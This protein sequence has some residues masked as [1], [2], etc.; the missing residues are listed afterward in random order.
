[1]EILIA[2]IA[3]FFLGLYAGNRT[4]RTWLNAIIVGIYRIITALGT[5]FM[6]ATT[7]TELTQDHSDAK[8]ILAQPK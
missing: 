6:T 8:T 5:A 7:K 4:F 1:M 2:C 3:Y